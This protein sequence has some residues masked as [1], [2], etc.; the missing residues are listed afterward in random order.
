MSTDLDRFFFLPAFMRMAY[1][2]TMDTEE[3]LV[4]LFLKKTCRGCIYQDGQQ[5]NH[6]C[7]VVSQSTINQIISDELS[8]KK[9]QT[10][11]SKSIEIYFCRLNHIYFE[12]QF[13]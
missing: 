7:L 10:A 3:F 12:K 9:L 6:T 13:F 5:K 11:I 1:E 2:N 8:N 4:T